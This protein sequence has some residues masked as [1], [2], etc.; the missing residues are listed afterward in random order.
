M[1][2][3]DL[4]FSSLLVLFAGCSSSAKKQADNMTATTKAPKIEF[5]A[6]SAY[7]YVKTQCEF[8]ARVP[9]TDAHRNAGDWLIAQL[10]RHGANVIVQ[11]PELKA[12]DGTVLKARNIIGE[13]NP[14]STHRILLLA[15]WDSRPWADN[16]NNPAKRKQPVM[17][18][19][20]GASGVGVILE[21]VRIL[22]DKKIN[23]GVDILFTDAEDWG[24]SNGDNENSW[25]LGTQYW[26]QNM[27]REN[28]RPMFGILLDMVGTKNARFLKDYYSM[29]YA[30]QLVNIVW[31]EATDSGFSNYFINDN[32]G[33]ITD[34]H[35]FINRAGI[36]CIDIIDQ[37]DSGSNSGFF[38]GWHTTGDTMGIISTETLKAVGQTVTNVILRY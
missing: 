35:V 3:R 37:N 1:K 8:G 4:L 17:G 9:N 30:S 34:D 28:Y 27:H 29:Q 11:A 13:I 20:D 6:D 5:N 18:A 26:T 12:F 31:N 25:A 7:K 36:P 24:D 16:D 19:N 2:Y 23:V 14:D 10:K 21:I 33:G 22:K 38:A 15:H 32:G